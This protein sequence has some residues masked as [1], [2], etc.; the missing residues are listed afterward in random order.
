L[1]SL[2]LVDQVNWAPLA[3]LLQNCDVLHDITSA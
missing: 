2:A 1:H 3:G